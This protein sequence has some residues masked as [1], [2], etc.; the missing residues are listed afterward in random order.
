MYG[1]DAPIDTEKMNY[2]QTGIIQH[3]KAIRAG[4]FMNEGEYF[5]IGTM[6]KS[7]EAYSIDQILASIHD[8]LA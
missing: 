6:T 1:L 5:A 8:P 3:Q 2:K 4:C 7:L